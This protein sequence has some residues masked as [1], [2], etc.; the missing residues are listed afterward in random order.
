MKL[1]W[2]RSSSYLP[3]SMLSRTVGTT[4]LFLDSR[5]RKKNQSPWDE[6]QSHTSEQFLHRPCDDWGGRSRIY[7]AVWDHDGLLA[8]VKKRK[9]RSQDPVAWRRQYC[10]GQWKEQGKETKTEEEMGRQNQTMDRNGIW[11]FPEGDWR[12]AKAKAYCCNFIAKTCKL[13]T[14]DFMYLRR[15]P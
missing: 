7:D 13:K 14:V 6:I 11:G 1:S 10:G 8:M 9:L 4:V 3:S 15:F 2:C 12:Y 5:S